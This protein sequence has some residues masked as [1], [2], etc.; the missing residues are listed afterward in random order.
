MGFEIDLLP[1]GDSGSSFRLTNDPNDPKQRTN[2][3]ERRGA[4]FIQGTCLDVI[5]GL[6]SPDSE[7]LV[8]LV[9]F[10]F[11][12]HKRAIGK[13]IAS[14]NITLEFNGMEAGDV[15]PEVFAIAPDDSVTLVPTSQEE[16]VTN[17]AGVNISG[18]S[19]AGFAAGG[20]LSTEK[21][22]DHTRNNATEVTGS[23]FLKG[24]SYGP[25]NCAS[26]D[27]LENPTTNTGVPSSIR[28]VILLKRKH[29]KPFQC[30][31]KVEAKA[32]LLTN[33]K[34]LLGHKSDDPL[35]FDPEL[36]PT[37]N[38]QKYDVESLGSLDLSAL[39]N[40]TFARVLDNAVQHV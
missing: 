19:F 35:L 12:F 16:H 22:V 21:V 30:K 31:V 26:W 17:K 20:E 27:L 1:E 11:N 13:R 39:A 7:Q 28:A 33:M 5:H 9:V 32:D 38:L 37:N 2:V 3:I 6:F 40:I 14:V 15:G 23:K 24:R 36:D 34:N 4:V 25:R 18:P 29:E 8:T 10:K